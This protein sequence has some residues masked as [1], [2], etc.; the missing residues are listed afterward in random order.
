[1]DRVKTPACRPYSV[2][3]AALDGVPHL[4]ERQ[5]GDHRAEHLVPDHAAIW[6]NIGEDSGFVEGVPPL[7]RP[8]G[9]WRRPSSAS[10]TQ[11]STRRAS[12]S[13]ISGPTSVALSSL[14]PGFNAWAPAV[15][16]STSSS[17]HGGV[18]VDALHREAVLSCHPEGAGH[19][20]LRGVGNV[21]V[22]ADNRG[23]VAAQLRNDFPCT[24]GGG[25][26]LR[27]PWAAREGDQVY[28]AGP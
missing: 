2:L 10:S 18:D 17:I 4:V 9:R 11:A 24:C 15:T 25:D 3:L 22:R 21:G 12:A 13:V 19:D 26:A 6:R 8:C 27:G 14:G 16:R 7:S 28:S 1:M 20:G 23:V 5:D